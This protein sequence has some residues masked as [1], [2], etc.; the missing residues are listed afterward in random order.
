MTTILLVV[1]RRIIADLLVDTLHSYSNFR[2]FSETNAEQVLPAIERHKP[3]IMMIEIPENRGQHPAEYLEICARVRQAYP[4]IK[5]LLMCPEKSRKSVQ[6][7]VAA[8][9]EKKV[10]DFVFYDSTL[11]YLVA[12]ILAL[13]VPDSI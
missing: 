12:K 2:V 6:A 8:V 11:D 1:Y 3:D 9:Q 5:L 7:A 4:A 10:D 13:G